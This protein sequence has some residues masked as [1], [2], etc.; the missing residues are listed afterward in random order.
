MKIIK[1]G[2]TETGSIAGE[3]VRQQTYYGDDQAQALHHLQQGLQNVQAGWCKS[4]QLNAVG[5]T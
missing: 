3:V 2:V 4:A 1:Y 5:D